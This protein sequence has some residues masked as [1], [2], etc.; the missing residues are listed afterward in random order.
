MAQSNYMDSD[1]GKKYR[2][3]T[4]IRGPDILSRKLFVNR[5]VSYP[6]VVFTTLSE[7]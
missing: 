1:K 2:I 6:H 3:V 4:C 5:A 7:Q